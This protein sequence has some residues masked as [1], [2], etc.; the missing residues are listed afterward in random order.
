MQV[1]V[2]RQVLAPDMQDGDHTGM[3]PKELGIAPEVPDYGPRRF[4]K[5]A[6]DHP[7]LRKTVHPVEVAKAVD[8]VLEK[9]VRWGFVLRF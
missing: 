6:V 7:V 2:Q 1:G 3:R 9:T 4:E 8:R 5:K